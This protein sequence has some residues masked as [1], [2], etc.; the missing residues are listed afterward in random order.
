MWT[1]NRGGAAAYAGAG[2]SG[3]AA[4]AAEGAAGSGGAIASASAAAASNPRSC[5]GASSSRGRPYRIRRSGSIRSTG[6]FRRQFRPYSAR[7]CARYT[8]RSCSKRITSRYERISQSFMRRHI[9]NVRSGESSQRDRRT[10]SMCRSAVMSASRPTA[11]RAASTTTTNSTGIT[12]CMTVPTGSGHA[13]D[14]LNAIVAAVSS[15]AV[16]RSRGNGMRSHDSNRSRHNST[17]IPASIPIGKTCAN[18][19]NSFSSARSRTAAYEPTN[20]IEAITTEPPTT[21]QASR[22]CRRVSGVRGTGVLPMV[23]GPGR[24]VRPGPAGS[25]VSTS[26]A[27]RR[28]TRRRARGR[29]RADCGRPLAGRGPARWRSRLLRHGAE[30]RRARLSWAARRSS[31]GPGDVAQAE[32]PL[33]ASAGAV[34]HVRAQGAHRAAAGVLS[35]GL[36]VAG[37]HASVGESERAGPSGNREFV[38]RLVLVEV[39]GGGREHLRGKA[40]GSEDLP[41]Y[42]V[43]LGVT[44]GRGRGAMAP[45]TIK[46]V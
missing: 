3:A 22:R 21:A 46:H 44:R 13:V 33:A 12:A 45:D 38:G 35:D 27:T 40:R 28:P 8:R 14:A 2:P 11:L 1:S 7:S 43:G 15:H 18:V 9:R 41:K 25:V 19:P 34:P 30:R 23:A 24:G 37:E 20:P 4:S 36:R 16:W 26:S 17:K 5:S 39:V 31:D 42:G 32:G 29:R 6:A 10:G